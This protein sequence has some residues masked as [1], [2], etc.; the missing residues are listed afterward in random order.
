MT[1]MQA[2]RTAVTV[3]TPGLPAH[4]APSHYLRRVARTIVLRAALRGRLSWHVA[5]AMLHLL[6]VQQ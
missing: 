5:F 3:Q 1:A 2:G 6:E 4:A